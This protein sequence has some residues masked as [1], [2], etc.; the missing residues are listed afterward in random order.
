M[1]L[2]GAGLD[3]VILIVGFF[4]RCSA[5]FFSKSYFAAG[6]VKVI[7]ASGSKCLLFS[8]GVMMLM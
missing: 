1:V 8:L 7:M 4:L 6:V 5:R 2:C 3:E